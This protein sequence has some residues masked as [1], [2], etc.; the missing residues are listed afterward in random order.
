MIID[1]NRRDVTRYFDIVQI[2][3]TTDDNGCICFQLV[4][5]GDT[6]LSSKAT[7]DPE[8]ISRI[9]AAPEDN[10]I[11][12]KTEVSVSISLEELD[13]LARETETMIGILKK[14]LDELSRNKHSV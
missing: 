3:T 8:E 6:A 5:K 11:Q 10:R 13:T 14:S 7:L 4:K 1:T 9:S 2:L 12:K